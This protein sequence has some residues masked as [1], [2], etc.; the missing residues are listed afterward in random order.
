MLA[1]SSVNAS[2]AINFALALAF[3]SSWVCT[4]TALASSN[5]FV[6]AFNTTMV[7]ASGAI[8]GLLVAFGYLFPNRTLIILPLPFPI[9]AKY[10]IIGIILLDLFSAVSGTSIFSSSNTAYIAHLGGAFTGFLIMYY[11]KKNQFNSNRWD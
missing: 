9:K 11:W 1:S 8:Y 4:S 3:K 7:G 5:T 2:P 10:L 6:S